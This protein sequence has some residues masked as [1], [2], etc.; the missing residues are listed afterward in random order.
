MFVK[1][2]LSENKIRIFGVPYDISLNKLCK[3]VDIYSKSSKIEFK[4]V[5]LLS[6]MYSVEE[7]VIYYLRDNNYME[8][9]DGEMIAKHIDCLIKYQEQEYI[10][11]L[12]TKKKFG[13]IL[14]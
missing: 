5:K 6:D 2:L 8:L 3:W 1:N 12:E 11:S 9:D 4:Y 7:E 13:L 14:E 10:K